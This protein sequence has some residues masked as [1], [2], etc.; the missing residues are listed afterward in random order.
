[1]HVGILSPVRAVPNSSIDF[2]LYRADL[3]RSHTSLC[4]ATHLANM[5]QFPDLP[6]TNFRLKI[7]PRTMI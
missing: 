2:N 4:S 5:E 3:K 7:L 6:V 1:M